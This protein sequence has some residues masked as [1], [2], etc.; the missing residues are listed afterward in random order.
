MESKWA[1]D[2]RLCPVCESRRW[3]VGDLVQLNQLVRPGYPVTAE[4]FPM[5]PY[6]CLVCG[7]TMLFNALLA[8]IVERPNND[9]YGHPRPESVGE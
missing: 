6:T 7:Y 9:P 2:R 8:G 3:A 4:V 5:F 1:S